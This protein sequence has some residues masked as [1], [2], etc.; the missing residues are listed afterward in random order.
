MSFVTASGVMYWPASPYVKSYNDWLWVWQRLKR[1]HQK[2]SLLKS[3]SRAPANSFGD[4]HLKTSI[5]HIDRVNQP[6]LLRA[7]GYAHRR[8]EATCA[9][10]QGRFVLCAQRRV[11]T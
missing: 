7:L 3:S 2:R 6:N 9:S 8:F 1:I 5:G 10:V 4:L 11:R